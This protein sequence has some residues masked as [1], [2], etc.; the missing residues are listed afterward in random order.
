LVVDNGDN[1]DTQPYSHDVD[2]V[3][4]TDP[5]YVTDQQM[6]M[7]DYD[8]IDAMM[9]EEQLDT[10][11]PLAMT[12]IDDSDD[13]QLQSVETEAEGALA[14][15]DRFAPFDNEELDLFIDDQKNNETKRKLNHIYDF[16]NHFLICVVKSESYISYLL[17]YWMIC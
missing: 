10:T 11:E 15:N 5:D 4:W 2:E 9:D 14:G 8:G 16:C 17:P 6:R 1:I 3:H 13:R 12:G 7:L